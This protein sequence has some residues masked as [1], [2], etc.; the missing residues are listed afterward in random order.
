MTTRPNAPTPPRLDGINDTAI[1]REW[2]WAL[3]Q[4]IAQ[5]NEFQSEADTFD[6]DNLPDPTDTSIATAQDVA[7]RAYEAGASALAAIPPSLVSSFTISNTNDTATITFDSAQAD[8]TA[9]V[10][11]RANTGTPAVSAFVVA[12][13]AK[14]AANCIVTLFAAPGSGNSVTFDLILFPT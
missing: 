7:N 10:Q 12:S 6:A 2:L 8:Y 9:I 1:V 3:Y 13:I 5:N 4:Y 14:T 11:A